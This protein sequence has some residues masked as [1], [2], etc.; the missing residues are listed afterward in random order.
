MTSFS[1]DVLVIITILKFVCKLMNGREMLT[2]MHA[3]MFTENESVAKRLV[4][5]MH[6]YNV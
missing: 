5:H 3:I 4:I 2:C 6:M 1:F